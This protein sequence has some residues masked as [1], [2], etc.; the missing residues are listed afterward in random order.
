MDGQGLAVM[1]YKE[2]L[3]VMEIVSVWLRIVVV[4]WVYICQNSSNCK[5]KM[6]V[7]HCTLI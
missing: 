5:L 4:P 3:E 6:G 7:L 1:G 2:V